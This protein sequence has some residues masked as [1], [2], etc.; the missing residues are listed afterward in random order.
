[1]LL[2]NCVDEKPGI[3]VLK[4]ISRDLLPNGKHTS[5]SHDYEYKRFGTLLILGILD[6]HE[7]LY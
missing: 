7:M 2:K 1:M 5:I 4:N 6:L 3:Q